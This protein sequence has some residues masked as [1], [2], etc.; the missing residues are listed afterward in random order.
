MISLQNEPGT[1]EVPPIFLQLQELTANIFSGDG[2]M[3]R[4]MGMEHRPQQEDMA[5]AVAEHLLADSPL[6]FEAGTGVGKSLAYLLPGIVL[7]VEDKRPFIVSSHTISLQEQILKKDIPLCAGFF[8]SV[9]ELEK[10]KDFQTALLVGKRNYLCANRLAAALRSKADL[11]PSREEAEL[12][13]IIEWSKT[14]KT[15]MRQELSPA[16]P[17]ET[18]SLINADS[19]TCNRK[20]CQPEQCHYQMAKLRVS[21]ANV[22]ILNHS[23]LFALLGAGMQPGNKTPGVLYP[24]DFVV[25]DEAH[26]IPAIATE[27]FGM[28]VSSYGLNLALKLLYN[29]RRKRGILK[30][31]ASQKDCELVSEAIR[32]ADDFF[33]FVRDA[34]LSE[35]SIVRLMEPPEGDL[36]SLHPIHHVA[37]RVAAI[38]EQQSNERVVE[39]LR[40]HRDRILAYFHN[41]HEFWEMSKTDHVHWFEKA[42]RKGSITHLKTAPID[43]APYLRKHLFSR[44]TGVVLT[45]ATL[46]ISGNMEIFQKSAGAED[47]PAQMR[48]SPF[49]YR[50]HVQA[51]VAEDSPDSLQPDKKTQLIRYLTHMIGCFSNGIQGGTLAL[52]TNYHDLNS[53]A[54]QLEKLVTETGR[55]LFVQGREFSRMEALKRFAEAGNGLLLGTDSF[56]TG[57]DVPGSALSQ[58]IITRLPFENPSHPIAQ[59]RHEWLQAQGRNPFLEM[60]LPDAVL[61]F[62]QGLGRLV[63]KKEDRGILT[64]L[65]SRI[66]RKNYGLHF[67]NALPVPNYTTFNSNKPPDLQ[68]LGI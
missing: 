12:Q 35:K 66:L 36:E 16:P 52:F 27:Y 29:P 23:L 20:N 18:W 56:W 53:V 28:E 68:N 17:P 63:R 42:G 34:F 15:G 61:K 37:Q 26:R 60:T 25:L 32:A 30:R 7:A 59:A 65:D 47:C 39:E 45:S 2:W 54:D 49:N 1:P 58:V 19:S 41:I 33:L 14:T 50:D 48:D 21:K 38:A 46:S 10:Y 4:V 13:R 43:V 31:V 8:S 9:P 40:D 67:L 3:E 5:N 11:F 62:R 57:V 44:G 24:R 22:L 51:F 64:I 6:L 55:T